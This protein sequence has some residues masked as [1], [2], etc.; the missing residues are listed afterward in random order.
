MHKNKKRPFVKANINNSLFNALCDTGSHVTMM[1]LKDFRKIPPDRRPQKVAASP[2]VTGAAG[3][4]LEVIGVYILDFDIMGKQFSFP[5][6]VARNTTAPPILGIDLMKYAKMVMDTETNTV[7]YK[8]REDNRTTAN[9]VTRQDTTIPPASARKVSMRSETPNGSRLKAGVCGIFAAEESCYIH[10][11]GFEAEDSVNTTDEHGNTCTYI[12]NTSTTPL[13]IK[14]GATMGRLRPL[15]EGGGKPLQT[16]DEVLNKLPMAERPGATLSSAQKKDFLLQTANLNHLEP[17]IRKEYEELILRNHDC[18][19]EGDHDLG[20][21]RTIKHRLELNNRKP[22]W[23]HQFPLPHAHLE[24][25]NSIVDNWLRAGV[26]RRADSQYNSPI[27]LVPKKLPGGTIG[28]RAVVDYRAINEVC[29]PSNFRLPQISECLAAIGRSGSKVFSSLDLRQGYHQIS[30]HQDS[31]PLSAFSIPGRGQFVFD[32]APFGLK[33][34]P[35]VFSRLMSIVFRDFG[36]EKLIHY[37]DDCL[38]LGKDHSEMINNLQQVFNRLRAHNLKLHLGK[39]VWGAKELPYL[40]WQISE[41]GYK[42]TDDKVKAIA[43]AEMPTTVKMIR[44]FLGLCNYLR[45]GVPNYS[46]VSGPLSKLTGSTSTWKP[47]TPMPADAQKSFKLLKGLLCNPPVLAFPRPQGHYHLFVDASQGTEGEPGGLGAVL[48]QEQQ[49]QKRVISYASKGLEDHEKNYSPFL[50]EIKAMTWAIDYYHNNLLSKPFTVYTDH[51]PAEKL[52]KVHTKT[53]HRLQEQQMLYEFDVKW[54]P[55]IKQPADFC[56]RTHV[57]VIDQVSGPILDVDW[58]AFKKAQQEDRDCQIMR[59]NLATGEHPKE[60]TVYWKK[61]MTYLKPKLVDKN[62]ILMRW[63]ENEGKIP[64]LVAIAPANLHAEIVHQAHGGFFTGHGGV[65]KTQERV[66][67]EFWWCGQADDIQEHVKSCVPCQ[68]A[69]R[70]TPVKA[71]LGNNKMQTEFAPL[72]AVS[73]DLFGPL[74]SETGKK[75]VLIVTDMAT[76]Y[77]DFIAIEDKTAEKVAEALFTKWI[78]DKSVPLTILSDRGQEFVSKLSQELYKWLQVDKRSTTPQHPQCNSASELKNKHLTKFLRTMLEESSQHWESLLG[79]CKLAWNTSVSKA[80]KQTPFSLLYGVHPRTPFFDPNATDKV[81]YGEDYISELKR[82]ME[83]ARRIAK[84]N[85]LLY[86]QKYT[87]EHD[88]TAAKFELITENSLVLL[89]QPELPKRNPKISTVWSGPWC[90]LSIVN[91][92]NALIQHV[93]SKKTKY[94]HINRLKPYLVLQGQQVQQQR[95]QP[96]LAQSQPALQGG[97]RNIRFQGEENDFHVVEEV[98]GEIISGDFETHRPIKIEDQQVRPAVPTP[99]PSPSPT[100]PSQGGAIPKQ[101]STLAKAVQKTT[102]EALD[103]IIPG[104]R[105]ASPAPAPSAAPS[106]APPGFERTTPNRVPVKRTAA[107]AL[108]YSPDSSREITQ[109]LPPGGA[110]KLPELPDLPPEGAAAQAKSTADTQ[111]PSAAFK[112]KPG[113]PLG[114][115]NKPKVLLPSDVTTR[116]KARAKPPVPGGSQ[117]GHV[118]LQ[119]RRD[120]GGVRGRDH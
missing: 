24:E 89:H 120:D 53:F 23:K 104:S 57:N 49:G 109:P 76:R 12:Y 68:Y 110:E 93:E 75:M 95:Q 36:Q 72:E 26:V 100:P 117:E 25:V 14:K 17:G 78:L 105:S 5:V 61:M 21:C 32:R 20:N 74:Q 43:E 27:F 92:C 82:R 41:S 116:S 2:I 31:T 16:P 18:F 118:A 113:R 65:Y 45:E 119:P 42:C 4:D 83:A 77:T 37:L 90:V 7:Y 97:G 79:P 88:K 9:L 62:G 33:N 35:L 46:Q 108:P 19:S 52:S 86:Q 30:M 98:Y 6:H 13:E 55:G 60:D 115:K 66:Q 112:R 111:P 71:P 107:K 81:F 99:S 58:E 48:L 51:K 87:K 84:Q 47:G 63:M 64:K 102:N 70:K 3:V 28:Y 94:V 80:T 56:S 10:Y 103:L 39:C 11:P 22:V 91:A 50:L 73:V 69:D 96:E 34:L 114:S 67:E 29:Y 44:S 15:R 85:N 54:F 8:D 1:S 38:A 101:L 59:K 106:A 40:G